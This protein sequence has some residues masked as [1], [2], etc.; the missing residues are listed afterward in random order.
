[1]RG[2][3]DD[4]NRSSAAKDLH[5]RNIGRVQRIWVGTCRPGRV[6]HFPPATRNR[7]S[8]E[9]EAEPDDGSRESTCHVR[10]QHNTFAWV[11]ATITVSP[12]QPALHRQALAA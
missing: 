11:R 4:F 7:S 1:M 5:I 10:A 6:V 9:R 8:P 2:G 12:G 3:V